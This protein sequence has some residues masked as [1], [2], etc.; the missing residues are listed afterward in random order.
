MLFSKFFSHPPVKDDSDESA[1]LLVKSGGSGERVVPVVEASSSSSRWEEEGVPASGTLED[2]EGD[3]SGRREQSGE[4]FD[5]VPDSKRRLG[6]FSAA[7]L[8]FNRVI[9]TGIFATPSNILRSSGSVGMALAMWLIGAMIA[10]CGSAVYTEL[11]TGLPR[12]GGEKNYFEF[13]YRRP[14]YI[15][16]CIFS[17]YSVL[18]NTGTAN[19]VV[20]SEYLLNALSIPATY[21][22]T[23]FIAW[24][25]LTFIVLMHGT[26]L[27][28]WGLRLQNTLGAGKFLV[29]AAIAFSGLLCLADVPGFRVR[30]G[31]EMPDNFSSW[32][33]FW[34]G[35][36]GK[37]SNAFV[38]GLYNV[39][40][41]FIGYSNANYALSEIKDPVRTIKRAAPLAM[42]AVTAVYIFINVAYFAAVSKSDILGSKRIVAALFF[43]N[44]FGPATERVLSGFIA[45]STLGN[46]L[47]GQFSQGR[48]VQELGREGIIPFSS[49]IASSKP[50][51]APLVAMLVQ[52]SLSCTFLFL[53][54]SGDAY[55]FMLSFSSY[56]LNIINTLVA[57]GLF[58]LYT[59]PFK[60]LHWD[61][62]FKANKAV[63]GMYLASNLFLLGA[64]W[65]PPLPGSRPYR[66]LPYW[67]HAA[68]S[69]A[70]SLVGIAYWYIWSRWLPSKKGYKLERTVVR[71]EDGVSR[72]VFRKV[73]VAPVV[74]GGD[75]EGRVAGEEVAERDGE[76]ERVGG[77]ERVPG[78][79]EDEGGVGRRGLRD[80]GR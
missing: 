36:K 53:V 6:L 48:V 28:P 64:P 37:G 38:S 42:C 62:P 73:Y 11:G 35:S 70:I 58:L 5:D 60:G 41:S 24:L 61:P 13:I 8:I 71:M 7:L 49:K 12:S 22:N 45:L 75:G 27:A 4:R 74:E 2:D 79:V 69:F 20:F 10:A 46:L 23:R 25:C 77:Y 18:S 17:I 51:N 47:A 76:R 1:S 80:E 56:S 32:D 44:L 9:G 63:V 21:F 52:Y 43:R 15:A 39:I 31:Y 34:E 50:F 57:V 19:S 29:L 55:L 59:R 16:T 40:W 66:N 14:K 54:P 3:S 72:V 33:K 30:E 26:R 78:E 67:S 65:I 68:G